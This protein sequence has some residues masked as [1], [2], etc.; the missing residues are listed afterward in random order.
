MEER[1][2]PS[3]IPLGP[4]V[5]ITNL[6]ESQFKDYIRKGYI[7]FEVSDDDEVYITESMLIDF[8]CH[9]WDEHEKPHNLTDLPE[10]VG[11]ASNYE[12]IEKKAQREIDTEEIRHFILNEV[13]DA[14]IKRC[15]VCGDPD[16]HSKGLCQTHYNKI[17]YQYD[18]VTKKTI[19]KFRYNS[20][21]ASGW[22]RNHD[23]CRECGSTRRPH[24]AHGYCTACYQSGYRTAG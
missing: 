11:L 20:E 22:S 10:F 4:A 8:F 24:H 2:F 1:V 19:E 17:N 12:D 6:N 5:V 16:L 13:D 7:D 18:E 23:S 3:R 15:H 9:D 21:V 14:D